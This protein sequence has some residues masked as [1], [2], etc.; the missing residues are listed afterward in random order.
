MTLVL[1][2]QHSK[3]EAVF[4]SRREFLRIAGKAR[5]HRVANGMDDF[6][7][8][9]HEVDKTDMRVIVAAFCRR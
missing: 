1:T 7:L 6:R 4:V 9:Q 3:V 8:Q 5:V 2:A